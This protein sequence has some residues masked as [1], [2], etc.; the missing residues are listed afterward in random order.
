MAR[1][2]TDQKDRAAKRGKLPDKNEILEFI[3]DAPGKVGKREIARAFGIKGAGRLDLNRLLAGLTRE[4]KLAG[5]R[6]GVH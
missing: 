5:N 2:P 6:K 1:K 3:R 4:G